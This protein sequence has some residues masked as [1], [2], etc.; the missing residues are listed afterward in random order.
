MAYICDE[1]WE[2]T[3]EDNINN[4]EKV[5]RHDKLRRA[6]RQSMI[7]VLLTVTACYAYS[8]ERC[9]NVVTNDSSKRPLEL[10]TL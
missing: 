9:D 3:H 6:V 10:N 7:T 8:I 1:W 4:L 2:V 5:F